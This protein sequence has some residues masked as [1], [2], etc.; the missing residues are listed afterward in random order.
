M[1][2]IDKISLKLSNMLGDRLNKDKEEKAVLKYGLFMI[3]HSFIGIILT[4]LV[5]IITST[6]IEITLISISGALFKRYTGGAHASTPE[7]CLTI[8]IFLS[9][10]FS[11]LSK[12][13]VINMDMNV[14]I[15]IGILNIIFSFF[16]IYYKCPVPSKNKPLKNEK[17]RK[18]LKKKAFNLLNIY[19]ILYIVLFIIYNI[20]KLNILKNIIIS[21]ILGLFVQ[22]L[23]LTNRGISFIN[24]LDKLFAFVVK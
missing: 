19:I 6:V 11:I 13:M 24:L 12:L 1:G 20:F 9:L 3:I 7:R 23:T 5:G 4:I 22:M 14:I 21:L 18:N 10:I 17:T 2:Y 8:G 15:L 16:M